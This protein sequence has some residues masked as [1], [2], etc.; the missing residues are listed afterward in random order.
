MKEQPSSWTVTMCDGCGQL[1]IETY[2]YLHENCCPD[3]ATQIK[4]VPK[5]K[6]T[7]EQ[8]GMEFQE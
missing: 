1:V 2:E 8:L 7:A 3:T 6:D 5:C 4:V